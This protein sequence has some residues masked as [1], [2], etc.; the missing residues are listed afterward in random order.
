METFRLPPPPFPFNAS[1]EHT[2]RLT[3]SRCSPPTLGLSMRG[4]IPWQA[5]VAAILI[6]WMSYGIFVVLA[7]V[8][9]WFGSPYSSSLALFAGFAALAI[10]GPFHLSW[11]RTSY[12]AL[13]PAHLGHQALTVLVYAAHFSSSGLTP[14][15]GGA[16]SQNY[17][18]G[19]YVSL[20]MWTT[21]GANDFI[22]PKH[23]QLLTAL[24]AL[25][26]V[27]FLPIFAAMVWQ[28]LHEMTAPPEEAFLDRKRRERD[29][30]KIHETGRNESTESAS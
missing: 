30:G 27:L 15:S 12:R 25:T 21:L 24:E 14:S 26:A 18:D 11:T 29:I 17:L 19:I 9:I 28:M 22:V 23:L 1:L 16:A 6:Q 2:R 4:L 5:L 20:A 8:G 13:V 7:L 3:A 10:L